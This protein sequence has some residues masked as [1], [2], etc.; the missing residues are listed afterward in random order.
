MT[1][2]NLSKAD[3][4]L[5]DSAYDMPPIEWRPRPGSSSRSCASRLAKS[6]LPSIPGAGWSNASLPGLGATAVSPR[7]SKELSSRQQPSSM[8]RSQAAAWRGRPI[9]LR[10]MPAREDRNPGP[11]SAHRR[12]ELDRIRLLAEAERGDMSGRR[13]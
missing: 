12:S 9:G 3:R 4:V 7:I 1:T 6:A 2:F 10:Y 5:A 13:G 8:T 11:P